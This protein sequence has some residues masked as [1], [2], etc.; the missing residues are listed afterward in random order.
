MA[1]SPGLYV[2]LRRN[3]NSGPALSRR[4]QLDRHIRE[5]IGRQARRTGA[6]DSQCRS[7]FSGR[8]AGVS[9]SRRGVPTGST[10]RTRRRQR[11]DIRRRARLVR[12]ARPRAP[13]ATSSSPCQARLTAIFQRNRQGGGPVQVQVVGH[14]SLPAARAELPGLGTSRDSVNLASAVY[15]VGR[16]GTKGP[17]K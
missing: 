2:G 6:Q 3:G 9:G 12:R 15:L 8:G 1:G 16:H 14:S 7:G 11:G 5:P 13:P 17:G 10:G 4:P